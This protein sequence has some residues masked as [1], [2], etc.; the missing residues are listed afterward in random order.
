MII[1]SRPLKEDYWV[2]SQVLGIGQNGKIL[3]CFG[4]E[5]GEKFALKVLR[6]NEKSRR[7]V[8]LHW[9]AT[10]C[11]HVVDIKD[12]Y[13]NQYNGRDCILVVMEVMEGGEL[14]N[15]I[16]QQK[17]LNEED[18]AHIIKEI[19]TAVKFLHDM[20]IAHRDLKPENI[21]LSGDGDD[22][23]L[24]L[25]DF[26]FAKQASEGQSLQTACFTPYYA[27]PEVL[28]PGLY[29]KSCVIWSLGVILYILLCGYP[30]FYSEDGT[31]L[32]AG[33]KRR[34]QGGQFAMDGDDWA[35]VSEE[36][37]ELVKGCLRVDAEERLGVEDV[38]KHPWIV[39]SGGEKL[40]PLLSP[41]VLRVEEGRWMEVVE[42]M[43]V[44]LREMRIDTRE[45]LIIKNPLKGNSSLV[46]R[47]RAREKEDRL[48]SL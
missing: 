37:K 9:K 45:A 44:A 26:G 42:G 33:M 27:A 16:I 17:S 11:P 1:K 47:R 8:S 18:A 25:T 31:P 30:P 39:T 32:S 14:F 48:L 4:I 10:S 3:E 20:N 2:S 40:N 46:A 35:E 13:E 43:E 38:L 24:K 7:E 28:T 23:V 15:R 5:S 22:A 19:A 41:Q 12:V 34:I 29:D 6:D 36:A 21:L